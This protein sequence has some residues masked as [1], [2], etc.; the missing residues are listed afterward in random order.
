VEI[1]HIPVMLSEAMGVLNP[2]SGGIYVDATVGTGGHSEE[3]LKFISSEGRLIGI[4][5]DIEALKMAQK[6]L[7]DKRVILKRGNFSDMKNFLSEHGISEVD[8]ILLDLGISMLQLKN[9]ERGFSFTSDKRLDMR[10][11]RDQEFSAWDVVNKYP[12]KELDRIFREFGEEHFAKKISKAIIR[13]RSKKTID[14]CSELSG[15]VQRVYGR[16]GRIHPAT[17]T[18]QALRIEVNRELDELRAGLDSSLRL[19]KKAGRLCIISYHS[20]EDRIVKHF[21]AD[22]S[23]KGLLKVIIKKPIV[24]SPEELR[25]NP[26]S[27]SAK[28]RGAERI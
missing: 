9:P 1:F 20:L 21:M 19:L 2:R 4:D 10:M 27:R 16:R 14:T 15:I 5:R 12:E 3:I 6:R 23:K 8:G 25:S 26:S 24:P 18:F 13:W 11:D 17:K 22:S 28:L 7:S